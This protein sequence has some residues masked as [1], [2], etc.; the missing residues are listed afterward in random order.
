[1]TKALS[2][3]LLPIILISL[4]F[5]IAPEKAYGAGIIQE[6]PDSGKK[7]VVMVILDRINIEDLAGDYPNIR[8]LMEKGASALMNT[9]TSVRMDHASSYLT[10]GA[11]TRA[12]AGGIDEAFGY[13]EEYGGQKA[14]KVFTNYTGIKP[15]RQKPGSAGY[16]QNNP[17]ELETGPRDC[18][19]SPGGNTEKSRHSGGGAGKCR[20]F[21]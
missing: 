14:G 15:L 8:R 3:L 11:G 7:L 21:R 6:S 17:G 5:E 16:A 10:I 18:S 4:L 2:L 13:N 12:Y 1:M 20:F 9:S 19:G